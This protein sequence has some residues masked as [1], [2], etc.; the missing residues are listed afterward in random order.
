[1]RRDQ[2]DAN[3]TG[4]LFRLGYWIP[5]GSSLGYDSLAARIFEKKPF[6]STMEEVPAEA[7]ITSSWLID[8]A[9]I[10]EQTVAMPSYG[11]CLTL[12]WARRELENRPSEAD[13]LLSELEPEEFTLNRER[14]PR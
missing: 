4:H 9:L 3:E 12:L 10:S 11:A 2:I 7:W 5:V 1:L 14:W 8:G 13:E 6:P